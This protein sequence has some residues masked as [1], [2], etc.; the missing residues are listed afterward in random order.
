MRRLESS[1]NISL[2]K[3]LYFD[4]QTTFKGP[5]VPVVFLKDGN[6]PGLTELIMAYPFAPILLG[7]REW[8]FLVWAAPA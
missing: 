6:T 8:L 1:N 7:E 4:H 3:K 5:F 2:L